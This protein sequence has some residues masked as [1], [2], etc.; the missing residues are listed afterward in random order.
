M[1]RFAVTAA[2]TA[3]FVLLTGLFYYSAIIAVLTVFLLLKDNIPSEVRPEPF[4]ANI[5]CGALSAAPLFYSMVA[6][7]SPRFLSAAPAGKICFAA[8]TALAVAVNLAVYGRMRSEEK[9]ASFARGA[10]LFLLN[11]LCFF[12]GIVIFV[13]IGL[14][15]VIITSA[16][17]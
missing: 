13:P 1:I 11:I 3:V 7:L 12:M 9:T 2:V 17:G 16:V 5:I 10:G 4:K 15:I 8:V 14:M 6:E